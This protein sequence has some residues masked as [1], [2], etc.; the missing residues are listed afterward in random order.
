VRGTLGVLVE[1]RRAGY[2]VSLRSV[3]DELRAEGFRVATALVT[4][5]LRQVG[6]E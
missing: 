1:A 3:L 5:A 4:E 2:L 6:E